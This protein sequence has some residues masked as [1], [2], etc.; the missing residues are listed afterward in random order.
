MTKEEMIAHKIPEEYHANPALLEAKDVSSLAKRLID[1]QAHVGASI[2]IPGA[3]AGEEDKKAFREKLQKQ[4]P[5]LVEV[6]ADPTKFAEVEGMI[7][8]KLGRPKDAKEYPSLKD[9]KIEVPA[10]IKIEE[11]ELRAYAH[12]LGFTKKQFIAF[13]KDVVAEKIKASQ[14]TSEARGALKKELGDAFDERLASAAVAAK[15]MGASDAV[16]DA[17]RTGNVPPEEAKRWIN[18]AKAIGAEGSEFGREGGAATKMTPQEAQDQ[19]A[20]LYRN[21]ALTNKSHPE[22]KRLSEKLVQLHR[23]AYPD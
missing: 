10:E 13:A 8:E 23:I 6:P 7:F 16:V 1:T 9:S 12:G 17:L 19:I 18:V 20:E 14:M 11:S 4:V 22:N 5:D 3:D 21:P 2:R 15:K